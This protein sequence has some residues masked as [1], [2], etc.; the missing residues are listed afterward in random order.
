MWTVAFEMSSAAASSIVAQALHDLS[1]FATRILS[2]SKS[3]ARGLL[4]GCMALSSASA[5]S[6]KED[7]LILVLVALIRKV[8]DSA[9]RESFSFAFALLLLVLPEVAS[10]SSSWLAHVLSPSSFCL[11]VGPEYRLLLF[12]LVQIGE[13]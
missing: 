1:I 4:A 7:L 2:P 12:V 5:F 13:L 9:T 10:N 8:G 11:L 3:F 6:S